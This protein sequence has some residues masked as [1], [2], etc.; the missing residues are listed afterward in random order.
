MELDNN[1]SDKTEF[2]KALKTSLGQNAT[3]RN[4]EPRTMI[5]IR[6]LDS[7]TTQEGVHNALKRDL[8]NLSEEVKIFVTEK[9]MRECVVFRE[10]LEKENLQRTNKSEYPPRKFYTE[11]KRLITYLRK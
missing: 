1:V 6:D 9:N 5:E 4:L 8:K 2:N 11:V 7:L 10:S 3:I